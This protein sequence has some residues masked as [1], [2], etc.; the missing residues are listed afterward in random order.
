MSH[1]LKKLKRDINAPYWA[2]ALIMI[3]GICLSIICIKLEDFWNEYVLDMTGPVWNYILF[4]GYFMGKV[5]NF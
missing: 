5:D 4:R 3:G 1:H 2:V